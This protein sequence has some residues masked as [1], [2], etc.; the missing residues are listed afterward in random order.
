LTRTLYFAY[1]GRLDLNTGGYAYDRRLIAGLKDLGWQVEMVALGEGFPFPDARALENAGAVLSAL[2]D[3]SLV[4]IDGLAFGVLDDWAQREAKRLDIVALVH[5]P[6][7]LETG[8]SGD[9]LI[10]L[11]T[12]ERRAL[13]ATRHVVVTSPATARELVAQYGVAPALLT[14]A[15]PGTEHAPLSPGN[16]NPPHILSI[17]TL[18]GRKGHDVLVGALAQIADLDWYATIVGSLDLDPATAAQVKRQIA[19]TGLED[20]IVLAGECD[21]SRSILTTADI[22]ALASRYEG[23]GMVFAE[24]LQQGVPI[25]ACHAGAIPDVVPAEAGLLVPAND[26]DAFANALRQLLSK[27]DL[28]RLM[29][30]AAAKAG[31]AL[32]DWSDTARQVSDCLKD[33]R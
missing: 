4:L 28:R 15:L 8:L 18:I 11:R 1:P 17:G 30:T 33:I 6:L 10:A 24:A 13:T 14:V 7:A 19:D 2:P 31:E 29:A 12:S 21:D 32:P 22:F 3:A 5:H 23:Y 16:G 9:Q 26:I 25:V 20:R 27:P